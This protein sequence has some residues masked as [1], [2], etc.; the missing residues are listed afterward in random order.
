LTW[1]GGRGVLYLVPGGDADAQQRAVTALVKLIERG[2]RETC[3]YCG[4]LHKPDSKGWDSVGTRCVDRHK[5]RRVYPEAIA[6]AANHRRR[7]GVTDRGV[8]TDQLL[9][10]L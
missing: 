6:H 9:L 7:M 2:P 8:I 4:R 1:S 10:E 3:T 5:C